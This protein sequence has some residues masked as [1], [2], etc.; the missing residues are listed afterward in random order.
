VV[1]RAGPRCTSRANKRDSVVRAPS[2]GGPRFVREVGALRQ[3]RDELNAGARRAR[4][5]ITP[6]GCSFKLRELYP[7]FA[8][9]S[10]LAAVL[11]EVA[12]ALREGEC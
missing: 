7:I 3:R 4:Y 11:P 1:R 6:V 5:R 2:R 9:V 10:E 12:H 8:K